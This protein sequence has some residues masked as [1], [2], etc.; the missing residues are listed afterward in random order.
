VPPVLHL[1]PEEIDTPEKRANYTVTL[2]G[3]GEKAVFY[4]LAFAQ[5]GF[6][7]N[8]CDEDQS[9]IKKL[10]K[11]NV[12]LANL[13]AESTFRSLI[14]KE[15][16][17][18]TS[19]L[20]AAATASDVTIITVGAKIDENKT[21]DSSEI[22]AA[23]RTVGS[24]LQK[25][26]LVVYAGI[27]GFSCVETVVKETLENTSGLKAGE[28]FGAAY[29]P[30]FYSDRNPLKQIG[31]EE[32]N[33]AADDKSSLNAVAL[34]YQTIAK[35]GVKKIGNVKTAELAMLFAAVKSDVNGALVNEM[36]IFC[37][38]AGIDYAEIVKL[39]ENSLCETAVIPTISEENNRDK[40]YLLWENVENFDTKLRLSR[41]ARQI[42]EDMVRYAANLTQKA[43][44]DSG[45]TFRR[46]KV[47]VLG[48]AEPGTAGAAFVDLLKAKGAKV[49]RYDPDG[50]AAM[51]QEAE[52]SL[53]KTLNETVE[54][55]DCVVILSG[56]EQLKRLN[57]KKLRALMKSPAALVD[58]VGVVEPEKAE[59]F[60]Y[61]GLG[62][63]KWKK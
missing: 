12:K 27:A 9:V 60:S 22:E 57:L 45:K 62:R 41:L 1:K 37:E 6:K 16:V 32:L 48:A 25:G 35:K 38:E 53:K 17:K 11:G 19:D 23:C 58:L 50:S 26:S 4:A 29:N 49:S 7:V 36:A 40:A 2:I 34:I 15:Q 52:S 10:A 31:E 14:R 33:V 39:L 24:A 54:G 47:A 20:K 61:R 30:I 44:H 63:G 59:G 42:N 5:A 18:V 46:A 51:Q 56:K 3:C 43:L 55:T 8:C 13:Q 28:D 21:S